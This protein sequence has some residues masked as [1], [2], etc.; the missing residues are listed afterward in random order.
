MGN[1]ISGLAFPRRVEQQTRNESAICILIDL[2][3][4]ATL[5]YRKD[6]V[7]QPRSADT[8]IAGQAERL[9]LLEATKE[10]VAAL[11]NPKIA[12]LEVAKWV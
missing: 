4:A 2:L 6:D 12:V 5:K 7:G 10:L 3:N 9:K 8:N 11:E 1:S